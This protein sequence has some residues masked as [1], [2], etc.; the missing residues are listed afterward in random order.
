MTAEGKTVVELYVR[1]LYTPSAAQR[2]ESVIESLRRLEEAGDIAAFSVVVWGQ[3]VAPDT[4]ATRTARG[5]SILDSLNDF[6]AW[7]ADEGVTLSSFYRTRTVER[8]LTDT[9][10]TVLSLPVMGLAEYEG[11]ELVG[12]SPCTDDGAVRRVEDHLTDLGERRRPASES[13]RPLPSG[14]DALRG[15]ADD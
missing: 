1:S 2:Q 4:D 9:S 6:E 10:E 7:A 11:G 14:T 13:D 8:P 15:D 3:H 5:Q 12:V